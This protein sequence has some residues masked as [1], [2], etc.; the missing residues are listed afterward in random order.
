MVRAISIRALESLLVASVFFGGLS[1]MGLDR[2]SAAP[3]SEIQVESQAAQV[4]NV[5]RASLEELQAVRGIGP[6]LAERI[7][8]Y[9]EEHGPFKRVDDLTEIRGIGEA[10]LEKIKSQV[11]I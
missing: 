2:L 5:N 4:I 8:Q 11:T 6:A 7:I 9:R 3:K 1:L 10:K